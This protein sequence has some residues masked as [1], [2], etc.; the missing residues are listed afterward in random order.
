M[1]KIIE[2]ANT[3]VYNLHEN[4]KYKFSEF[5]KNFPDVLKYIVNSD[6]PFYFVLEQPEKAKDANPLSGMKIDD[7]KILGSIEMPI[8]NKKK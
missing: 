2:I 6:E 7:L 8:A 5:K 4:K 1:P 3:C